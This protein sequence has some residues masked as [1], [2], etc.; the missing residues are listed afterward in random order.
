M[1]GDCFYKFVV[2]LN[3]V[4]LFRK[5]VVCIEM[6]M[7]NS[8]IEEIIDEIIGEVVLVFLK[9]NCLIIILILLV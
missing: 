8:E 6:V 5:R 9:M 4:C 1:R 7:N 3:V 2:D